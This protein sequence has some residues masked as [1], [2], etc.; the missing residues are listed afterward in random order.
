MAAEAETASTEPLLKTP[1]H[2]R[3]VT[4]GARMVPFAGYDMPVQYPAGIMAEHN[5][6]RES[7][8]LFDVSHMGQAFLVGPDHETTARALEALIPADIVNLPPGKQR[9]SQLLN[10][11]GGILDDLM[12]TRSADPDEDGALL[13][14]VNAACKTQDYAHIEARLP[15]NVKLVKAEHRG[16]I[17]LQGPKAEEA[18]AALNPEAAEMGFMTLRT[19]KLGGVKANVS[20]SG[21]TGEDGYEISAAA[22]R[23]GEIWDALLLDA[24]VKPIGLGARDSLRL[25]AGLCLY[26]HDIDATTSP[27]EAAL[28]WSIQKR[29]R[30]EGGFPGA[31]RIQ[32]EF[33]EG[34]SRVRVGLLP[35]GRAPAREGADI[36]TADGTIVG[37]VT[38]G[39]FGPTLNGPCAMGYVA[40]EH[41]APG[42]KLDLI[43]R[44]KPLP[45]TIAA[46]PF[47]PN[48]YKR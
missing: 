23:I 33:A 45:A 13:L 28:N 46:M 5:W 32:R 37:K 39:G 36:A 11:E 35:E 18:L 8:G 25:E 17:A 20:R 2:A 47:V 38:S 27:V 6:T 19:L 21:Y 3:H 16:L 10:E 4:L 44:G 30:E 29:R 34:V 7:A 42:T 9:Y 22:D 26:G 43:V 48:R 14:V 12:V 40:K 1:F 15:A 24:R 31:A 41:S